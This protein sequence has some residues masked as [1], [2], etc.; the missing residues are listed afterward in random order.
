MIYRPR[1][2]QS[3]PSFFHRWIITTLAVLVADLFCDGIKIDGPMGYLVAPLLLGVLNAILKP[4]LLLLS[5]PLL[6]FTLGLFLM[7][8]N[9]ILLMLTSALMGDAF[10]VDHF[11]WAFI[12]GLIISVVT[13]IGNLLAKFGGGSR[14]QIRRTRSREKDRRLNDDDDGPVIDV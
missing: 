11:G 9:A 3:M 10:R 4:L 12:G 6:V 7:V 13:I 8:I 2:S 1:Q 5:L 14:V